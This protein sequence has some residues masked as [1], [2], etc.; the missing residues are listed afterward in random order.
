VP[1]LFVQPFVMPTGSMEDT[2]LIGDRILVQRWPKIAPQR[3]DVIVFLYPPDRSQTFVK[4]VAGIAGDR[5]R[6]SNKIL[7]RNGQALQEPY[8]VHKTSYVDSYR[9]NF[10]SEPTVSLD[11]AGLKMLNE[12]VVN[13]EVVVPDGKYFVL[14]DNRDSSLD[15]R[16]WG[17]VDASDIIGKPVL[18]YDS[19]EPAQA[20][21]SF[22]I[23]H[24]V[25]WGRLFKRI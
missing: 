11:R 19:E 4:R 23:T 3:D 21:E 17:F 7:Y 15:S 12:H 9:D 25:R 6:I 1:I 22:T 2:L 5:I 18:I 16:Y 10:P 8:A 20:A 14:G 24:R 13:G